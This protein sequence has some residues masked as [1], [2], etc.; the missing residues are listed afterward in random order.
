MTLLR[1]LFRIARCVY[2]TAFYHYNKMLDITKLSADLNS[3][4]E[5]ILNSSQRS[6][7]V[8]EELR[9][10]FR[11]SFLRRCLKRLLFCMILVAALCS[12]IHY[13]PFLNW[14]A[15]AIGRLAL[16]KLV[17]PFYH[18]QYLYTARCLIKATQLEKPSVIRNVGNYGGFTDDDCAVCENLGNLNDYEPFKSS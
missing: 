1:R 16:I 14:N 4:L 13:V 8:M 10:H 15:S 6:D 7:V 2:R 17:L 3:E 18:W 9:A 12:S 5:V 11:H